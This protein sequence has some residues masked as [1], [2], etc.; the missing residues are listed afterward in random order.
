[1]IDSHCHLGIDDFKDGIDSYLKR[2]KEEGV[3]HL[4]TVACDYTQIDDLVRMNEYDNVYTAFGIH[5]ENAS[6]FDYKKTKKVFKQYPFICAVGETGLDYFYNPE[7]K[8]LQKEVFVQHIELAS[9]LQKPL[10]I[11]TRNADEETKD[12][13]VSAYNN[14]LLKNFGVM[15]C[16]CGSYDLAKTALDLGFY[17]SFSGIITFKNATDLREIAKKIPMDRLLIETD[18]PYLAPVPF[19]GKKNEP[20]F[21]SKTLECLAKIKEEPMDIVEQITTKNFFDL[22]GGKGR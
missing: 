14:N 22:F 16:F 2:A 8:F 6:L 12:I 4:L 7:T 13:L 3:S 1:M 5:P 20:A 21:V 10:I 9:E 18:A 19:R 17:I 15:H 11:H